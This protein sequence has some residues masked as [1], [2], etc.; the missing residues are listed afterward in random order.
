M[1]A[2]VVFV[3]ETIYDRAYYDI[4]IARRREALH[5]EAGSDCEKGQ[6]VS[7]AVAAPTASTATGW[8]AYKLS[9]GSKTDVPF[10]KLAVRP[11]YYAASPVVIWG[12]ITWSVIFNLLPF[13][14]TVYSQIFSA[15]PYNLSTSAVGLISGIPPLIGTVA[16]TAISGP[17]SD[18]SAKGL[19]KRAGGVYEPEYRLVL[20]ILFLVFGGIGF[21]GWGLQTSDDWVVPAVVRLATSLHDAQA[22]TPSQFMGILHVGISAASTS[23]IGYVSD[24]LG[25]GAPD[26]LGLVV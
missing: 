19:S 22:H 26:A 15:P 9:T 1:I 18:W 11:L 21:Y 12:S 7:A 2:T 20:M 10:W 17:L 23:C 4:E 8:R 14:A 24:S 13:I 3:Q 25:N 6:E 16:G 5:S